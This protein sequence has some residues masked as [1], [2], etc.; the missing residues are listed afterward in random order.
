[1][2]KKKRSQ[3]Y[4]LE[5]SKAKVELLS[6]YLDRYLNIIAN[7]GYTEK[8]LI[9]DLFCGEGIYENG[10][11]GSPI[12]ILKKVKDLHFTNKAKNKRI[13]PIDIVFNDKDT[14]KI[15]KLKQ[16]IKDKKIYYPSFG[17]LKFTSEDYKDI[18]V[19]LSKHLKRINNQKSFIFIDPYGYKEISASEI[20]SLLENKNSEVLLFLPTQFMY[21]FD[22]HG[23][24]QALVDFIHEIVDF[25]LWEPT[26]SVWT[27]I[28][29]L[30]DGFRNFLG[31]DYFVD[32]FAIEKDQSTVFSLFFFSSHIR[33]F[34][35]ML[36]AKWDL[37]KEKGKGWS[38]EKTI[39][40]FASL[41]INVLEEKLLNFIETG[42]RYN[43]DIYEFTLRSG[44]LPKHATEI[45][46]H[47]QKQNKLF[48]LSDQTDKVRKG[49]FYLN[50]E[51]Y[52]K[53]PK[54][55]FFKKEQNG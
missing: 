3:K 39:G 35:K 14:D 7:D 15:V 22:T 55:V 47:L 54:R 26:T 1:M 12:I 17:Q 52:K 30:K 8:I 11:E 45:F 9:Y 43:S 32:T 5:H 18:V 37:D 50:Y 6:S 16:E 25:K 53:N 38:Y 46:K 49:A 36:E 24:P 13:P 27:F 4:L 28:E 19:N 44:F 42:K 21:R 33:G 29:Q 40:L 31:K 10:G 41:E 20:K 2:A 23:T 48:I 51:N 34:E